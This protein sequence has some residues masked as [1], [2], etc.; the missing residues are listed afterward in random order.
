MQLWPAG[1]AISALSVIISFGLFFSCGTGSTG[2]ARLTQIKIA[3]A[4]QTIAKGATLQLNA[5]GYYSDGTTHALGASVTWQT[6]QSAVATINTQGDVTGAGVGVAQISAAY[7][8][9]TGTTSVTVGPPALL[10]ITVSPNQS[11]LPAGESAQFTATGNF[12]DGTVQNLTQSATW[13]SSAPGVATITAGGL[14]RGVTTGTLSISATMSSITG[15][16]TLT[17]MAPVLVSIAVTPANASIAVGS[18][19]QLTATGTYSDGSTQNLTS[20]A[21]WSSSAPSVATISNASGSQGLAT[22]AGLGTT[23]MQATSGAI[24]GSTALT[25]TAGFVLTGSLNTARASHTSTVLNNGMVLIAGGYNGNV[26]ASAELYNPAAGTFTPTGSLNT[27]RLYHTATLLDNGMVLIAGGSDNNGKILASAELYNPATGTFTLTGSLNTARELQTAAMINGTTIN[28]TMI[29]GMVLIAGGQGSGGALASA[30]LYNPTT[31]TFAT[32]GSLNTARLYHTATLMNNGVVLIA[33]G[34]NG[35]DLASAEL[36]N[37]TAATFTPT[38]SLNSA[39]YRHTATLLNNGMVLI[40]AGEDSN[41]NALA[42][43]EL[44]NPA[45]GSFTLNGS[46][47]TARFLHTSTLLNNGTD[48]MAGG[49]GSSAYLTAA[50]LNDPATGTF[51]PTGSLN[52][53]R[54]LHTASLLNNGMDLVA[55]GYNSSGY[56]ASAELYETA[57]LTPPN[58]VSIALG[59]SSPTVPLDTTQQLIATGTFGDGSTERLASVTWSSSNTAAVSITD[60]A[61]NMGAAY[62]LG[63]GGTATVSACTGSV[64]GSTVVTV[65]PPALVSIAVTPANGTVPEGETLPFHATGTYSDGSKKNLTSS[66][67]WSSSA[68]YVATIAAGGMAS[69]WGM[70]TSSISAT[71]GSVTGTA[72]LTVTYAA[73][74]GLNITPATLFMSVGSSSQLLAIATLSDESTQEMS[75]HVTWSLQGA[76]IATVSSK[77][78]VTANQVG[79]ATIL[80]QTSGFTAS[81]SLSVVPVTALNIVPATLSLAPGSSSQLQAIATLNDGTTQNLTG[82][83]TWSSTQPGIASVSSGGLVT[84]EQAGSTAILAQG[85]G[86]SGSVSLTVVPP[87]ALNIIPATLSMVLGSSSQLQAMATLGDGTTENMTGTG[88]VA[89]S[90]AQPGIASVN[91][92]GLATANQVGSTTIL[93]QAGGLTG[94][95]TVTVTP[96]LLVNYFD[97][98]YATQSGFDGTVRLTNTGVTSGSLCAMVYVFDQ[99]QIL[100]ECCGC[101]VSDSGLLTLSLL[102]DLTANTLT[103]KLPQ[104]GIIEVV[105]SDPTQNPQCDPSSLAP[106]GMIVGW[107]TNAQPNGDGTFQETETSFARGP[108]GGEATILENECAYLKQLG[109]GAGICTCGSGD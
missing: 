98:A 66:V 96:L 65:G 9:V 91:S 62:A 71:A 25:V 80:A 4:N 46:L 55:G 89:W 87:A 102:N 43:T 24:N 19:Q 105:S 82:I 58:L 49:D 31:G 61:S 84:A 97:A 86:F 72:N 14:A 75:G 53:G 73:V 64:C 63:A 77:G 34:Y 79:A 74:I 6:T 20:T 100:N 29:N 18:T 88:T 106:T 52:I 3:P 76:G 27:G 36:Y 42:S 103:G 94:S 7:E 1:R 78:M 38:L 59:P 21:A 23:T 2:P 15:S 45:T 35:G 17:V 67:T 90:S 56:L 83:V 99:H 8:G 93:A 68:P 28:G 10:S 33:G 32:T 39:R 70:G 13:S 101:P 92:G 107:E 104:A 54:Y 109:S 41:G 108:L 57:S 95:V 48:L 85:N 16:A 47:N 22:T 11:S 26:L 12:S 40:A 37:P 30:E 69:G 44:Y 60:D 51:D 50:E 5:T 81:A